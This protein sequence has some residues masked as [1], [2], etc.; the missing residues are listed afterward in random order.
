[1]TGAPFHFHDEPSR[2]RHDHVTTLRGAQGETL[3]SITGSVRAAAMAAA[4]VAMTITA[5]TAA[6]PK[7]VGKYAFMSWNLCQANFNTTSNSY[8]LAN[9][10]TGPGVQ[11]VNPLDNGGL[12]VSVGVFTFPDRPASSG[13]AS[14]SMILVSGAALR[15]NG[16]G[17]LM[18]RSALNERG[19]FSLTAKIFNFKSETYEI[20]VANVIDGVAQ[21]VYMVRRQNDRCLLAVSATKQNGE[22]LLPE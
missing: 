14:R 17:P 3:M 16:G 13:Q 20:A 4:L 2:P 6:A 5:A 22:E 9:G 10:T 15:I 21:T 18:T 19:A 8:R 7:V 12:S 11:T 1:L